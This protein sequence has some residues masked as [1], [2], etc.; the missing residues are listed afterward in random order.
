M[1]LE[2]ERLIVRRFM[3]TDARRV[4]EITGEELVLRYMGVWHEKRPSA[5]YTLFRNLNKNRRFIISD[6]NRYAIAL[7][8]TDEVIGMIGV[9]ID[10]LLNN[11]DVSLAY[12]M[13]EKYAGR[14]YMTEC[15]KAFTEYC[16]DNSNVPYICITPEIGNI[17]SARVAQKSGYEFCGTIENAE[18]YKKFRPTPKGTNTS[19]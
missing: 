19:E 10:G 18:I 8:D 5:Y 2:T 14:G 3:R 4:F 11:G 12:F 1:I 7:P 16:F 6:F 15:V 9:G 17:A 13:S